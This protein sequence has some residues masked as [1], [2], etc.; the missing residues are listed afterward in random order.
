[1]GIKEVSL[2]C[3][4]CVEAFGKRL[5]ALETTV[6]HSKKA[7]IFSIETRLSRLEFVL[8]TK[9]SFMCPVGTLFARVFPQ[10]NRPLSLHL[11]ELMQPND[12]R[13]T[14][15]PYNESSERVE[16]SFAV[17]SALLEAHLPALERLALDDAAFQAAMDEKCAA[18]RECAKGKILDMLDKAAEDPENEITKED[19]QEYLLD[20]WS[21]FY[22]TFSQLV[23]FT[24]DEA[25]SA[26]LTGDVEK[27]KKKYRKRIE[28]GELPPYFVR[29]YAFLQTPEAVDY[30][31][32]PESCAP[33]LA[34]RDYV[35][36]PQEGKLLLVTGC[37]CYACSLA[38]CL[39][40]AGITYLICKWNAV[41]VAMDWPF[42]L[43][44]PLGPAAFGS[45]GLRRLF[46]PLVFRKDA[47]RIAAVDGLTNGKVLNRIAGIITGLVLVVVVFFSFLFTA[48][49]PRVFS[50][51]MVYDNAA[52][53]PFL[54]P[55]TYKYENL[56]TVYY[57]DGRYNVYDELVERGSY[58][59]VFEDGTAID[60]DGS[61]T[62]KQ[63]E[64]HIL[65][66]LKPYVAEVEE[67]ATDRELAEKYGK[68]PDELFGY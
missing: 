30:Q 38:L 54:N 57:I 66:L 64:E 46:I 53:F 9:N 2:A 20:E 17:L 26:F 1:M 56:E 62:E 65:P 51:R 23:L 67:V 4:T 41:Y 21:E 22:E 32:M 48:A 29:L 50:D 27:A 25:Y 58:V 68:T 40:V 60:L 3:A 55:V 5:D 15:F 61:L 19:V 45:V 6:S 16:E 49:T 42:I 59:L 28:K 13:C 47:K 35:N 10:K 7:V 31:P 11:Y 63:T 36:G 52:N 18:L 37:A 14:Y 39:L 34:S 24:Q 44:L 12:F 43:M 8:T 33:V